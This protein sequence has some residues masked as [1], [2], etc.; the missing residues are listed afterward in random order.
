MGHF[1]H[2]WIHI[3]R[4]PVDKWIVSRGSLFMVTQG[5][6]CV[7]HDTHA[8]GYFSVLILQWWASG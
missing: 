8:S 5:L 6:H 2:L 7:E 3:L 4:F 1:N